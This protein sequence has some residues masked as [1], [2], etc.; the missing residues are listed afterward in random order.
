MQYT[1]ILKATQVVPYLLVEEFPPAASQERVEVSTN[2]ENCENASNGQNVNGQ[3]T[4][5]L[6]PGPTN[7]PAKKSYAEVAKR[8]VSFQTCVLTRLES[9]RRRRLTPLTLRQ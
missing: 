3:R 9:E 2:L 6:V 7:A 1:R 4:D 5:I 8:R